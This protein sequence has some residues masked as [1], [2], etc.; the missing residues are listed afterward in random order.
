MMLSSSSLLLA[1]ARTPGGRRTWQALP[2]HSRVASRPHVPW[3]QLGSAP[4]QAA[5]AATAARG[6]GGCGRAS[7]ASVW[8]HRWQHAPPKSERVSASTSCRR[9]AAAMR[10]AHE[11]AR[12]SSGC[13]S[14]CKLQL[15]CMRGLAA[16]MPAHTTAA[17][18]ACAGYVARCCT[19]RM[20][21]HVRQRAAGG[22]GVAHA[23]LRP[24][25]HERT[26]ILLLGARRCGIWHGRLP[27]AA[28]TSESRA[29]LRGAISARCYASV[30]ASSAMMALV[31]P[32]QAGD[33]C[34]R[35]RAGC[36]T[37]PAPTNAPVAQQPNSILPSM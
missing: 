31:L 7:C 24:A 29:A 18:H 16:A 20:H 12:C 15:Q 21:V 14:R 25:D 30:V 26:P 34:S 10:Q 17:M 33:V 11:R 3:R 35:K 22:A 32:V 27:G 1:A 4:Q 36:D 23:G 9:P 2:A 13:W 28:G 5:A 37:H 19:L 6:S 8:R